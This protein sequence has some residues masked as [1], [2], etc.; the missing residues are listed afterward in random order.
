MDEKLGKIYGALLGVAAGDAMGMPAEMWSRKK[1]RNEF[2]RIED[3]LP[4]PLSN[5]ISHGLSSYEVTDDT[6]S[7]VV[8]ARSIIESD[9]KIRPEQIVKNLRAWAADDDKSKNVLGPSTKRAFEEIENGIPLA[10]AG[11]TGTTNGGAM[12][13]IPV[14]IMSRS[15]DLPGLVENVRLSCLPTHNTS[16][17]ISGASAVAAAVAYG[18]D[19]ENPNL[20]ELLD[21]AVDAARLGA[22]QGYEVFAPS[23][24]RRI[25]AGREIIAA[26]SSIDEASEEIYSFLGTGLPTYEAIPAALLIVRLAEGDP[27]TSAEIAANI[28]GDTDT[29]GAMACGICG[30][31]SGAS[32]FPDTV[33]Q[34]LSETNGIDF[35]E[36][37]RRLMELRKRKYSG[38]KGF[39]G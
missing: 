18:V 3:F 26:A 34:S 10:V 5:E 25:T 27:M 15:D 36:L 17:A 38:G 32:V 7:T 13:I 1:I 2:G 39:E 8:I 28:G 21:I 31:V 37:A 33:I 20:D 22:E 9:G 14:G 24:A 4:G 11:R 23:V 30:A 16:V 29:I 35:F 6:L 19:E 12:R